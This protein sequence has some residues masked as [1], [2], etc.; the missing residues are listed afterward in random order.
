MKKALVAFGVVLA[1]ATVPAHAGIELRFRVA[2][3]SPD[4]PVTFIYDAVL[5][6]G[7]IVPGSAIS[8][9]V[10]CYD[11]AGLLEASSISPDWTATIQSSGVDAEDARR[12]GRDD[13]PRVMNATWTYTGSLPLDTTA[14]PVVL[15]TIRFRA[16]APTTGLGTC[17]S[18]TNGRRGPTTL[19]SHP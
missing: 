14:G 1:F 11:I 5:V 8:Q 16:V 9:H 19:I 12:T 18:Q 4:E 17:I 7:R 3:T 10:T 6:S 2:F 15:S 13:S